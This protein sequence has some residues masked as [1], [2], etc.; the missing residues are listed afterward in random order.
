VDLLLQERLVLTLA[1]PELEGLLPSLR[2]RSEALLPEQRA[3][4]LGAR[5][6][7][8]GPCTVARQLSTANRRHLS[9]QLQPRTCDVAQQA[10]R[11][12]SPE[13]RL[14]PRCRFS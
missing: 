10:V 1:F 3:P 13:S 5:C 9:Q 6:I 7:G 8:C 4:E 2:L 12:L 11:L 14:A